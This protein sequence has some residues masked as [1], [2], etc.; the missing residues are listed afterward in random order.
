MN[1]YVFTT[2]RLGF[3]NWQKKDIDPFYRI[4]TDNDVMEFFPKKLTREE[5]QKMVERLQ[6][7]FDESGYT[8]FAVD[9]LETSELIGFIG[10]INATFE[11]EFTPCVEIGWRLSPSTWNKGLATEGAKGCLKYAFTQFEM[12]EIYS[13]TAVINKKSE[14]IMEK[15][16]MKFQG[17][18]EHP[19]LEENDPLR[20]HVFY[21]I[22]REEYEKA[23]V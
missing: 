7:I 12:N 18:F 16:G 6:V 1:K 11:A 3:R 5:T 13:I 20:R 2:E 22:T 15:I 10:M 21:K 23:S 9:L 8:F 17:E 19:K 4:N 14:R